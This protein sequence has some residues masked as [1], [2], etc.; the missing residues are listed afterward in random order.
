MNYI[1][2]IIIGVVGIGLGWYFGSRRKTL[3]LNAEQVDQKKDNLIRVFEMAQGSGTI[4]NDQVEKSLGVSNATAER[5]LNEL[6]KEGKLIQIGR[7]GQS[8]TYRIR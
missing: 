1:L 2:Y 5:Y 8:V 7:T 3:A 4:T 6:E